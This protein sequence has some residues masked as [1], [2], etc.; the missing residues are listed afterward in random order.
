VTET[1]RLG[2]Q[3]VSLAAILPVSTAPTGA[4]PTD[5]MLRSDGSLRMVVDDAPAL[6]FEAFTV[7]T[8]LQRDAL[9][10]YELL[11]GKTSMFL[12][13]GWGLYAEDAGR[14][15]FFVGNPANEAS[16][17]V[18]DVPAGV[19]THV[20]GSYD[21][22]T[23]RLYLNG[24]LAGSIAYDGGVPAVADP[25][26]IGNNGIYGGMP[27]H[28]DEVRLWD[29]ALSAADIA[30][31]M[32]QRITGPMAGLVA[33]WGFDGT[34]SREI[35][36]RTGNGHVGRLPDPPAT[37]TRI[38]RFAGTEGQKV[39]LGLSGGGGVSYRLIAPS[40]E[41]IRGP[42]DLTSAEGLVLPQT[43]DYRLLV[44]GNVF[45]GPA[46]VS[47]RVMPEA[48]RSLTLT[49]GERVDGTIDDVGETVVYGFSLAAAANLYFDA[50]TSDRG[51]ITWTLVGPRG[52]E[53]GPIRFDQ[54][55]G[56]S[57][58]VYHGDDSILRGLPAGDYSLVIDGTGLATGDFAFRLFAVP[59]GT[60][61]AYD[62]P[63]DVTLDPAT[64]T[65]GFRFSGEA[66]DRIAFN[67][68]SGWPYGRLIDPFGRVLAVS[69]LGFLSDITLEATGIYTVLIEGA[70]DSIGASPATHRFSIGL[71][72]QAPPAP[73]TGTA[74]AIGSTVTGSIEAEGEVDAYLFTLSSA[75]RVVF[76]GIA[77]ADSVVAWTMTGPR[78]TEVPLRGIRD[79]DAPYGYEVRVL[80]LPAGT[81]QIRVSRPDGQ[82]GGDYA[83]RL[84]DISDST[85]FTLGE[86][87]DVT[88]DPAT[89]SRVFRF[90]GS[91]GQA[92]VMTSSAGQSYGGWWWTYGPFFRVVDPFGRQVID[93]R[94]TY[95][96]E[97]FTL[98]VDGSYT[99]I[100]EGS[101]YADPA[102]TFDLSFVLEEV[103]HRTFDLPIGSDV[104]GT[105]ASPRGSDRYEFDLAAPAV[106][107]L[108]ALSFASD[109]SATLS[110]PAGTPLRTVTLGYSDG[111]ETSAPPVFML[112]AG[113]Y[114]LTLRPT[115]ST[116]T[117]PSYAFRLHD[118][119]AAPE[120]V[121]G[122]PVAGTLDHA[123][124]TQVYRY[125]GTAGQTLGIGDITNTGSSYGVYLR[126]VDP[127]GRGVFG[128]RYLGGTDTIPI[129][130]DGTC[131]V[132]VE[133][134]IYEPDG[135][136]A[137]YGFTLLDPQS[138]AP[139]AVATD[140]TITGDIDRPGQRHVLTLTLDSDR[141]LA[142][143]SLMSDPAVQV[144]ITGP[145]GLNRTVLL[146][147]ADSFDA[148]VGPVI[149]GYAGTYTIEVRRTDG[150]TGTYAFALRDLGTGRT[151]ALDERVEGRLS[152]ARE[153]DVFRFDGVA[154]DAFLM[155]VLRLQGA[156]YTPAWRLIDPRGNVELGPVEFADRGPHRL[157]RTG[158]YTLLIEGRVFA[159][160]G[161]EI[162]Y[163]FRLQKA[164]QQ[165]F[166]TPW[167]GG[168]H[169]AGFDPVAG[170]D[171]GPAL[172]FT[173]LEYVEIDD[174]ATN[175]TGDVSFELWFRPDEPTGT[176]QSLVY[177]GGGSVGARQYTLWLN[178]SGFLHLTSADAS[179]QLDANS[180]GGSVT[181]GDW[182]HVVGVV[183][184][185]GRELRLYLNGVL[186]ASRE[187]RDAPSVGA[188]LPLRLG[189]A[190]EGH[191]AFRG[192]M[193]GFRLF[194]AALGA[195]DAAALM[196]GDPIAVAPLVDLPMDEAD[197][198]PVLAD[199]GAGGRDGQVRDAAA[200]LD[201]AFVGRLERPGE[202]DVH[203]FTLDAPRIL[204]WD[205]LTDEGNVTATLRGPGGVDITRRLN[206]TGTPGNTANQAFLAPAGDYTLTFTGGSTFAGPYGLRLLDVSAAPVLALDAPPVAVNLPSQ[207]AAAAFALDLVAGERVF[208][209]IEALSVSA[210]SAAFRL[211][212]T[213]GR[214]IH[215]PVAAGDFRLPEVASSGRYWLVFEGSRG[216]N[217]QAQMAF[218]LAATRV[219]TPPVAVTPEGPN[220]GAGPI[221]VPGAVG[222]G[223]AL[224]GA[225][226]VEIAHEDAL[227]LTGN[228]TLEAWVRPEAFTNSA[229]PLFHKVS[230][231][232]GSDRT[233]EVYVV[234][235]GSIWAGTR[236]PDG[237]LST[238][239]TA[240]GLVRLGEWTHLAV[241]F[242]RVA[243]EVRVH[244]NGAL[245]LSQ[246]MPVTPAV[247]N[248]GPIAIGRYMAAA[249]SVQMF[250]GAI[251]EVRLWSVAR[252][253][254]EI[255]ADFNRELTGLET[256]LRVYLPFETFA[257]DAT[258][259]E[260]PTGAAARVVN[261]NPDGITGTIDAIGRERV[262]T[263]TLD[264]PR[265]VYLDSLANRSDLIWRLEGPQ[266]LVAERRLSQT[267]G[268]NIGGS[269]VMALAA[270]DY[271]LRLRGDGDATGNFNLVLRDLTAAVPVTKGTPV[272]GVL[273]P[274]NKTAVVAFDAVAG[275]RV[276][277]DQIEGTGGF[278]WRL[279]DPYGQQ[280]VGSVGADDRRVGPLLADGRYFLLI[281]GVVHRGGREAF[282]VAVHDAVDGA[283]Q[284]L[285]FNT[286]H[287]AELPAPGATARFGF[288]LTADTLV[289]MDSL[290]SLSDLV[291][292][293]DGPGGV[294]V[295]SRAFSATDANQ[296][297]G[298]PVLR[299]GAGDYRLTISATGDR[300]GSYD[301]R[302]IDLATAA[303]AIVANDEVLGNLP[304]GG[305][306]T[307]VFRL[308][309]NSIRPCRWR[310]RRSRP[311]IPRGGWLRP[312]AARW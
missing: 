253:G 115:G 1:F 240:G 233:F 170:P 281:E 12:N 219:D 81:Y 119:A 288:T 254:D 289:T 144:R 48:T 248:T 107:V 159:A 203:R 306:G 21:G 73:L 282:R 50:L 278:R 293:L 222:Q 61:I 169:A 127:A 250:D 258:A 291:W 10:T 152:P 9:G 228:V 145:G 96:G 161:A 125:Q 168:G 217:P 84:L 277:L 92:L 303:T 251:D 225:E 29:R 3:G 185:T 202:V 40:G 296:L 11:M 247:A 297:G 236:R 216:N 20:A 43:G 245:A 51:D 32:N 122:T 275:D 46:E 97:T 227:A 305:I 68:E 72:D 120:I 71:I 252:T 33:S 230:E 268:G 28:V 131:L 270:G 95:Q 109:V 197:G 223:L 238:V 116:T 257:G 16:R 218:T 87:V 156:V 212:D 76:D 167:P 181:F 199:A 86:T 6:N 74:I 55:D 290:H 286:R 25:F 66:G 311:A 117:R 8:W 63:V 179:G 41:V 31:R 34:P 78:G 157:M 201:G 151:I 143:D 104:T 307:A 106:L 88:L 211:I 13:G 91:A 128:P 130:V 30:A 242:D 284:P 187:L 180:P 186:A 133:G 77:D 82:A 18:A 175:I 300:T 232:G 269:P 215:G 176:W 17:V 267:D 174:P 54:S 183:D 312:M 100:I 239:Q 283:V 234:S 310:S 148:S 195:E 142:F 184:R 14:L 207:R 177:S 94:E 194:G 266:G 256:G 193:A 135:N 160:D 132:L 45:G 134:R 59:E 231:G 259:D 244:V 62:T 210:G 22:T 189:A 188:T 83:F 271:R 164:R 205:V 260:S 102:E 27:A 308:T 67:V 301:F 309:G 49:P 47:V 235:N 114:A 208:I 39:T 146:R 173:G 276:F 57:F 56:W 198:G 178:A 237:G 147:S 213:Y 140:T 38:L 163:A 192:A 279:I 24:E 64:E 241:V 80:D 112:P 42:E 190:M 124:R 274:G 226:Y 118:A 162:D 85:A 2:D 299:L 36:D 265:L 255:L 108:D 200:T 137:T 58:S 292:T 221:G 79:S 35:L 220:P 298:N 19:W 246:A 206:E 182:N 273:E 141:L 249:D 171:G 155:D 261:L 229:S 53:R 165:V 93:S 23:L 99:L 214:Q 264:S 121:A 129:N 123:R 52:T 139:R 196:A 172:G 89:A 295:G 110:G 69:E 103:Q 302:L 243:G 191:A 304:E 44:E 5:R 90:D 126:V 113:R 158:T 280:T 287:S 204:F 263:F 136:V 98:P 272:A 70:P 105:L 138:P 4:G 153:T 262:Y 224:R 65:L 150:G 7:E 101:E 166:D 154:G 209:D 294:I 111:P 60:L 75:R 15:V 149:R 285:T 37:E 26:L